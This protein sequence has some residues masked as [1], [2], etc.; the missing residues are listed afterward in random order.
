MKKKYLNEYKDPRWQKKRLEILDRDGWKCRKCQSEEKTLHVHHWLYIKGREI[1]EYDDGLLTTLCED[2]HKEYKNNG[3]IT[4]YYSSLNAI[5]EQTI[6]D[7]IQLD[8]I[9]FLLSECFGLTK[10]I[11][12]DIINYAKKKFYDEINRVCKGGSDA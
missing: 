9:L 8:D 3:F 5:I 12:I 4:K 6:D 7:S 2:C 10:Q 11:K 1:W